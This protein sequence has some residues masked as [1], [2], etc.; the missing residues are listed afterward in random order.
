MFNTHKDHHL[1][2]RNLNILVT[3]D[4]TFIR[5]LLREVLFH[6]GV[7]E[8]R[9]AYDGAEA[10]EL[11]QSW[12][13]DIILVDWEMKPIDGI[14]FVRIV[15]SSDDDAIKYM[16]LIMVSAHS[17]FWRV[18][19]ARQAGVNEF[20]AKPL[21]PDTLFSRIRAVIERPRPFI[22]APGFFGPDRRRQNMPNK[23][24]RRADDA[25]KGVEKDVKIGTT[26]SR[27]M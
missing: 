17:E 18:N 4:C 7:N 20:L 15:R 10:L 16:P 8:I 3:D 24:S 26:H 5:Q 21:S 14:E 12:K 11:L 9:E 27:R 1:Y 6:F 25:K 22:K 19:T 13:P 23:G 2:L